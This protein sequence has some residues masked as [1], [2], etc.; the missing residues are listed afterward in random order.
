MKILL[1]LTKLHL[2]PKHVTTTFVNS[3][4]SGLTSITQ[5]PVPL[6]PLSSTPNLII[7]IILSTINDPS[8]NYAVCSRSRTF[9]L[10]LSLKHLNP[11]ISLPSDALSTGSRSL[12]APNTSSSHLP[13]KFS[14]P[15]NLHLQRPRSTRSSSVVN[16]TRPPSSSSLKIADLSFRYASPY[17]WNQLPLSLCQPHFGTS[18]SIS[19]SPIPSP[20]AS[21]SDSPLCTSITPLFTPGLKPY[22]CQKSYPCSF[23]SSSRGLPSRTIAWTVSS[24][25][26]GFCFF[27]FSVIFFV[28][29]PCA[30][31]SWPS[32]KLLSAR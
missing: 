32:R 24:E 29:V 11:V 26:L 22:P 16:L 4:V 14:Q 15:P 21:S 9:L 8:L 30:R 13:T 19:D 27:L 28:S 25:L 23:T 7:V 20:I 31:L 5:L 3:A 17:L 10:V 6:L 12:N 1:S 2:F 18:S